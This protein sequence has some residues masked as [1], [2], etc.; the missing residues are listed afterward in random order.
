M[1]IYLP[2]TLKQA[3][4]VSLFSLSLSLSL[5]LSHT[6]THTHTHTQT[7]TRTHLGWTSE[8]RAVE[9]GVA[10]NTPKAWFLDAPTFRLYQETVFQGGSPI[11]YL[12]KR[13]ILGDIRLWVG[14]PSTSA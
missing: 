8:L 2:S 7:N 4:A 5:S 10:G 9:L 14:D 13:R 6:H 3:S 11:L 12:R 1:A